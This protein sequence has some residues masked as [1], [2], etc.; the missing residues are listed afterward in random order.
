MDTPTTTMT[1]WTCN[2]QRRD[3]P[4]TRNNTNNA[5]LPRAFCPSGVAT[6]GRCIT[7][8]P[9]PLIPRS[10]CDSDPARTPLSH[11]HHTP[12][13]YLSHHIGSNS[14]AKPSQN[15]YSQHKLSSHQA[16]AWASPPRSRPKDQ[17][18]YLMSRS[19]LAFLGHP[20]RSVTPRE[21]GLREACRPSPRTL[22]YTWR[23]CRRD[24]CLSVFVQAGKPLIAADPRGLVTG[25]VC[26]CVVYSG[27][28][29]RDFFV[30][31]AGKGRS[32]KYY[33]TERRGTSR[34]ET[35]QQRGGVPATR[36]RR[37]VM[38]S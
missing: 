36:P 4:P 18:C 31:F 37:A 5:A 23:C 19:Y 20:K 2:E 32:P 3:T 6:E 10:R 27:A 35:G 16:P 1:R 22:C 28:G 38:E 9:L 7:S 12:A 8:G 14:K 21:A 25:I 29:P 13:T 33:R 11:S 17:P 24:R 26:G 30:A 15:Q 34:G